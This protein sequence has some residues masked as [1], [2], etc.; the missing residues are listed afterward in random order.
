MGYSELEQAVNRLLVKLGTQSLIRHLCQL[1]RNIDFM[2]EDSAQ[3]IQNAIINYFKVTEKDLS[4][5]YLRTDDQVN[6]RRAL[7][8]L[9]QKNTTIP[10]KD[11][12]AMY[13]ISGKTYQRYIEHSNEAVSIDG[14]N[15]KLKKA[16][17][18]IMII[19]K[20]SQNG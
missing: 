7:V 15:N 12:R 14:I 10:A 1:E 18:D 2:K 9:I 20:Q 19:L 13:N 16:I 3:I 5:N 17:N 8:Y 6:A 11:V 4:V